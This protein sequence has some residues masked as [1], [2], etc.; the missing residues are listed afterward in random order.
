MGITVNTNLFSLYRA[1]LGLMVLLILTSLLKAPELAEASTTYA[2]PFLMELPY[3]AP[4][5]CQN[6]VTVSAQQLANSNIIF[7][8][9]YSAASL[10]GDLVATQ[11]K[12]N[13][14]TSSGTLAYTNIWNAVNKINQQGTNRN[15]RTNGGGTVYGSATDGAFNYKFNQ[16]MGTVVHSNPVY[17]PD[18]G[19]VYV[20]ANDGLLHAFDAST[21]TSN[22][23]TEKFGFMGHYFWAADSSYGDGT[24]SVMDYYLDSKNHVLGRYFFDG[25]IAI[26]DKYKAD[27]TM[28]T[29]GS[30][31]N[32]LVATQGRGG[33][34]FLILRVNAS[35]FS[36]IVFDRTNF[37]ANN[38]Y[39]NN[40]NRAPAGNYGNILSTPT[41]EQLADGTN[42]VIVAEGYD[43]LYDV[44][45]NNLPVAF[46][47][48]RRLS[49]GFPLARFASDRST[50]SG[51]STP[52][53]VRKNGVV[54]YVYSSDY[55]GNIWKFDLT[56]IT[57]TQS[58][59]LYQFDS[60]ATYPAHKILKLFTA[61]DN[62]GVAQKIT[63]PITTA[64]S[65]DSD[66]PTVKNKQFVFFS[67]GSDLNTGDITSTAQ[68]TMYGLIDSTNSS[69][70]TSTPTITGRSN[71]QART[72]N[73][74]G[75]VTNVTSKGNDQTATVRSF[76]LSSYAQ[77]AQGSTSQVDDMANKAGWYMDW[78]VPGSG[79]AEQVFTA[80]V[81]R[82]A[83]T[84]TLVVSSSIVNSSDCTD[85]ATKG[86]LN[87]MDAYHGG[88]LP[89]SYLYGK[90]TAGASA[91]TYGIGANSYI[92]GSIDLG[93]GAISQAKFI[94]NNILVKG[95]KPVTTGGDTID[96]LASVSNIATQSTL[97]SRRVSWREI[98]N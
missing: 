78:S 82:S 46:L 43:N 67:T 75:T 72:I 22:D 50:S 58:Y 40:L 9:S 25:N 3:V 36:K 27:Q 55:V 56:G 31:D 79:A 62:N 11:V 44:G 91:G 13:T 60:N 92:V 45:Q 57:G 5:G 94:G 18:T 19:M 95:S 61:V 23:G 93:V 14:G 12:N 88:G 17:S 30:G 39:G 10:S 73:P 7:T 2:T 49:D 54:Q 87:A 51:L 15:I 81:L 4:S 84:P 32:Y 68:Q 26:S 86:Y 28:K 64:Y 21:A 74:S 24:N 38:Y 20:G 80:P 97:V 41:I 66:D 71:L 76:S 52:A 48:I 77:K 85:S 29:E 69:G 34:G 90:T 35:G 89:S 6:M 70:S 98:V 8:S 65:S 47:T 53:V 96:M 83:S 63:S 37:S 59:V 1:R 16:T 33:A 42:V